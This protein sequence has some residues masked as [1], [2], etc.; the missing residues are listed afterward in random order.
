M[1]KKKLVDQTLDKHQESLRN[2]IDCLVLTMKCNGYGELFGEL[3]EA[4]LFVE[5]AIL[6][7]HKIREKINQ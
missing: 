3:T 1:D 4:E 7:I 2:T 6:E 5:R